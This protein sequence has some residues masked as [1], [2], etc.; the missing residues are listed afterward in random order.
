M[1]KING[2]VYENA[3]LTLAEAARCIGVK[4]EHLRKQI[5]SGTVKAE[6]S[7]SLKQYRIPLQVVLD[8]ISEKEV[9]NE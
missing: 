6:L 2:K 1:I 7:P 5:L 3:D 4:Y 9:S 8:L